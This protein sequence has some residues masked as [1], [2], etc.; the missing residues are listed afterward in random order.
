MRPAF[1][2]AILLLTA[3]QNQNQTQNNTAASG[4]ATRGQAIA[5]ADAWLAAN[6][7]SAPPRIYVIDMGDRW[8][9]AY[10]YPPGEGGTGGI[11]LV[12]VNKRSG[13]IVHAEG[14]Q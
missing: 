2:L 9:L 10:D 11:E 1:A 5:A 8:R 14:G 6:H 7:H 12:V 4:A 3:C 13:E